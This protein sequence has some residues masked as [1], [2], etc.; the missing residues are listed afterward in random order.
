[1]L[2]QKILQDDVA[3]EINMIGVESRRTRDV[4]TP[5]IF[6]FTPNL[7]LKACGIVSNEHS[8]PQPGRST[9]VTLSL[10]L[11]QF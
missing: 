1:M 2:C 8:N 11:E 4:A 10:T 5:H 3:D 9:A 6:E 7:G